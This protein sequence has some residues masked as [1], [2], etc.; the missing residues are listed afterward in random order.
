MQTQNKWIIRFYKGKLVIEDYCS[1][2]YFLSFQSKEIASQF[3][4]N[5]SDLIEKAKPLMS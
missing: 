4:E 2:N 5:F 1:T 3:L